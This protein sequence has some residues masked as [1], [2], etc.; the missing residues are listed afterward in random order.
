[1]VLLEM[2]YIFRIK[3]LYRGHHYILQNVL[4]LKAVEVIFYPM[5]HSSPFMGDPAPTENRHV[6]CACAGRHIESCSTLTEACK[7]KLANHLLS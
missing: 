6:A 7:L 2:D 3:H 5:E 4:I 1:M